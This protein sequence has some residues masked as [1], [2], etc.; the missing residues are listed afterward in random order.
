[1]TDLDTIKR[2]NALHMDAVQYPRLH[3]VEP[4][5]H[6][7]VAASIRSIEEQRPLSAVRAE[8]QPGE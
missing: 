8:D 7:L 3:S 6:P 5:L 2:L 4:R 1:M